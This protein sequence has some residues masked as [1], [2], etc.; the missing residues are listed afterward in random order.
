MTIVVSYYRRHVHVRPEARAG[1]EPRPSRV[2]RAFTHHDLGHARGG[3]VVAVSDVELSMEI[4]GAF[5][6][7]TTENHEARSVA[8]SLD[9]TE[10][11]TAMSVAATIDDPAYPIGR[12][13]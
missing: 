9:V 10:N 13:R 1:L 11:D 12:A 7:A 5:A 8:V 6:A 4:D 2:P 3:G